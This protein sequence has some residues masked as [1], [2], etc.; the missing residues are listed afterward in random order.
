M[1]CVAAKIQSTVCSCDIVAFALKDLKFHIGKPHL[2]RQALCTLVFLQGKCLLVETSHKAKST[3][4]ILMSDCRHLSFCVKGFILLCILKH[5]KRMISLAV[6]ICTEMLLQS[7]V[8]H[9][10]DIH[11]GHWSGQAD[12][13]G[14]HD[15]SHCEF[16]WAG[17]TQ[18][19]GVVKSRHNTPYIDRVSICLPVLP[20]CLPCVLTPMIDGNVPGSPSK[21]IVVCFLKFDYACVLGIFRKSYHQGNGSAYS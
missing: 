9:G 1:L 20:V 2:Q 14:L 12:S 5:K 21:W 7:V 8:K 19:R 3:D 4:H 10:G 16:F 11:K 17:I 13:S 15:I 18:V 6:Y